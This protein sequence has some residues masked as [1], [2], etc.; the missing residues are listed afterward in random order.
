MNNIFNMQRFLGLLIKQTRENYKTYLLSLAVMAGILSILMGFAVYANEGVL[1]IRMQSAFFI[2]FLLFSGAIFT[3]MIFSDLGDK[4]KAIPVLT[5]PVSNFERYLVGWLY[6]FVIFQVVFVITFYLIDFIL[7]SVGS[8]D[9]LI[10]NSLLGTTGEDTELKM[11]F[12]VYVFIHAITFLGAIYFE[13]MHFIKTAFV[14]F[15]FV[16]ALFLLD[17]PFTQMMYD[18]MEGVKG[19]PFVGVN[20]RTQQSTYMITPDNGT[21]MVNGFMALAVTFLL[22]TAAFFKLKEKQV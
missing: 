5:L 2:N 3:S 19:I 9:L 13:R 14:F 20:I 17:Q 4:K 11:A 10:K 6:S 1:P 12:T 8:T 7:I 16:I 22:W 15:I 21:N 18:K